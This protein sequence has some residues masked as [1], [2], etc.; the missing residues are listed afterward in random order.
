MKKVLKLILFPS[1]WFSIIVFL[2][3]LVFL[4]FA[5]FLIKNNI[6][7]YFSYGFSFYGLLI[8]CLK[9]SE[10]LKKIKTIKNENKYLSPFFND[11]KLRIN[12]TL[13]T[14][15]SWNLIYAIF[16]FL[17]GLKFLNNG[18]WLFTM[19][20]YYFILAIMKFNLGLYTKKYHAGSDLELEYHK[21]RFCGFSLLIMNIFVSVM[22]FLLAFSIKTFVKGEIVAIANAT[23]TFT[24]F[25]LSI[26][27]FVKY[28]KYHSP[29]YSTIKIINVVCTSVSMITLTVTMLTTFQK[30]QSAQF[31]PKMILLLGIIVSIFIIFTSIIMIVKSFTKKQLKTKI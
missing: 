28:K 14:S 7:I 26:I 3:S 25:T 4:P 11:V 23:Y 19:A 20:G 5:I 21:M 1:F 2:V 10:L 12:I 31:T 22:I 24:M 29:V 13:Y 16:Q 6:I 17:L 18:L 30:N 9:I 15:F 27:N 8:F